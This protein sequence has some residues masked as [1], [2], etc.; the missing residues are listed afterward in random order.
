ML[1][2]SYNTV[3]KLN[4]IINSQLPSQPPFQRKELVIGD[5]QL[6]FYSCNI[7]ECI[8]LLYDNLQFTQDL[9]FVPEQLYTCQDCCSCIY[10]EMYTGDWWWSVQVCT[11]L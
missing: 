2:L 7:L 6:K 10:N 9:K 3:N 11:L 8:C 4:T 1:R 5:E